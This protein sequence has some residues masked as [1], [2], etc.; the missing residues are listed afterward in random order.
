MSRKKPQSAMAALLD[1][2]ENITPVAVDRNHENENIQ[3][4]I[5][6]NGFPEQ[7]VNAI[8]SLNKHVDNNVSGQLITIH[9]DDC[10]L[11]PFS[12]RP[13]DELG[14]IDSLAQSLKEHG[15]QE[16]ILVRPNRQGSK[17]TYEI[18]FGNRRWQAAQIAQINLI[19]ICKNIDDQQASLFQKEENENREELSDYARA[20]SYRAQIDKGIFK[21]EAE[22]SRVLSIS[23]Q[24][25]SDLM[26][27]LRVPEELRNAIYNYKH[28]SKKM[29]IQLAALAKDKRALEGLIVLAPQ[30]SDQ[31]ITTSNL[32]NHIHHF[33]Y[34][35][36]EKKI[37]NR[38][39]E[40]RDDLGKLL[41]KTILKNN[42]DVSLQII[43]KKIDVRQMELIHAKFSSVLEEILKE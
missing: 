25:L 23:K 27:Y 33:L 40:K 1:F 8:I 17:H 28:L 29:V 34:G 35:N 19:A 22:L 21:N 2:A 9:P 20:V 18:I 30:I 15:Q 36:L 13:S 12:D 43:K 24:A 39:L 7:E 10:V 31:S 41:Y 6:K 5:F 32:G 38:E 37:I 3:G 16:P 11:W 42:G 14:D 4:H 26:A